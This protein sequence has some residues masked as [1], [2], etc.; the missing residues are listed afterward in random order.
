MD[1][2]TDAVAA[3]ADAA[4]M[5]PADDAVLP[6]AAA[7]ED[8]EGMDDGGSGDGDTADEE[9]DEETL[10]AAEVPSEPAHRSLDCHTDACETGLPITVNCRSDDCKPLD[11]RIWTAPAERIRRS[12][13]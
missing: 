7:V 8:D 6:D 5:P 2:D 11:S 3:D 9:E 10:G 4:E 1:P 13:C 12:S